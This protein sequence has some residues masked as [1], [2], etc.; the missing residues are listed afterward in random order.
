MRYWRVLDSQSVWASGCPKQAPFC[1]DYYS[2][3]R[4][5]ET[6][7]HKSF[8][9]PPKIIMAVLVSLRVL[10]DGRITMSVT[11]DKTVGILII[12]LFNLC[13]ILGN[14]TIWTILSVY[15]QGFF[16]FILTLFHIFP[17]FINLRF[18]ISDSF[19]TRISTSLF[20]NG[21]IRL[22]TSRVSFRSSC[23]FRILLNSSKILNL[24]TY[25]SLHFYDYIF[26]SFPPKDLLI[27]LP[28]SIN[29]EV[30]TEREIWLF[31]SVF[32]F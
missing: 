10:M 30:E 12:I 32:F 19:L 31:K 7:K 20:V 23:L 14:I 3:A 13:I 26:Y 18:F 24:L 6:G 17:C 9:F 27:Y 15:K 29:R 5:F 25:S 1:I 28:V 21:L 8:I 2:L 22:F 16:L 11:T 4:S